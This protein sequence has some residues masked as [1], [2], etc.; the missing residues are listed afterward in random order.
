[1]S[2]KLTRVDMYLQRNIADQYVNTEE[3]NELVDKFAELYSLALSAQQNTEEAN[4]KNLAKWRKAYY[5]TLNALTKDGEE[6]TRKGRSLRKMVYE[7]IES[8]IDNSIPMPK[9]R[10]RYK[11][12]LPLVSVTEN[13]LKFEVDGI[14]TKYLNDRSERATYVDGTSW[15]KVWWDSLDNTHERS[16][17]VKIDLCRVDQIVPQP[18]VSDYRQLEYIFER[19]EISLTRIWDLYHRRII[20]TEA[21]TNV[22]EVI[23]CYYLNKDRVVGLFMYAP[24]SRQVICNEEDWQI[25]KLRTC[26]VCGTVN[27][28]GDTCRNCGSKTFKYE[29]ATEEILEN[30]IEEIYNPYDVGETD[31]ES[32]KEHYKSRVFLTAGTKIPFYKITQLPFIPRPAISSLDNIY[33]TSE[34]KVT[35]ESQDAI[36]KLLTKALEKTMKSG[37]I[38]TKP[39]KLKIGDSDDTIKVLSVRTTEEAT[40]VQSRPVVADT[41]Q[42]LVMAATL[43]ES[44]KASSGVT[45]SFQ[46]AKDSSATSGKAKQYAAVMTA[47]RIESLRVMKSAAFAGLYELVLKYLLAFSD[48]PRKFVR[49]L[50][51]GSQKEEVWNKY[52]FLDKDKYGN[53]YYRDDLR[54]DSDPA[55]T[56]SQ[57]R[58]QM[59]QE[60]QDKFVQGAF[61]NPADPRVLE[62]FWNIMDSL[63]YPLAKVVLAGIKENSQHLPP[64][65]EQMIMTN[66]ELQALIAQTL[67]SSGEQR[68]GARPN[69]GP[70]GNGATHASNVERTNERNRSLN[71][72]V[73]SSPQSQGVSQ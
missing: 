64:E 33:G 17:N 46:G 43:Y 42:D 63:Q 27:P 20:P 55:S 60:T 70:V 24:H 3:E 72:E 31:D 47:G 58:A 23:S 69:S 59:W 53:I 7:L 5:G 48:E 19:K 49:V 11:T 2:E 4:P 36:N 12:D 50:P 45:E 39:E 10:P 71:R 15:Y 73:I 37:T 13:Y 14:F 35:L 8:K 54:F 16:G 26:T 9:I 1:M 40:M 38:L 34:V 30:D 65:V 44:G 67:Q 6:S 61:G 29:N 68:G 56:L 18:G 62:L 28:T 52:M 66:P 41:S 57:N 25:R 32:E 21:N 51:N 22:I